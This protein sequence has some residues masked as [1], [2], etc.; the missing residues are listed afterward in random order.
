MNRLITP[1][2]GKYNPDLRAMENK[3]LEDS[4]KGSV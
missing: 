4:K 2:P 3:L 1:G